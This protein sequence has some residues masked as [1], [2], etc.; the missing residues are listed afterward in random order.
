MKLINT[1]LFGLISVG[2]IACT[3][4]TSAKESTKDKMS[5]LSKETK[6]LID[7]ASCSSNNQCQSIGF[8]HKACGG[9][10]AYRIYSNMNTD[11]SLLKSKVKRYNVLSK[12]LN[13]KNNLVSNCMM[14]MQPQL[15]CKQQ[16]CIIK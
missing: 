4:S 6:V 9:F 16:I 15:A 8:G 11:T 13:K 14:L 10:S 1:I 3:A 5:R 2:L 7:S 12:E